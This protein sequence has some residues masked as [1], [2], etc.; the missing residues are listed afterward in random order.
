MIEEKLVGH[1]GV[2]YILQYEDCDDF[3]ILPYEEC[4]QIWGVC[5]TPEDKIVVAYNGKKDAWS[6]VG[7]TIE[8]GETLDQTFRREIQE[9][10]N[11]EV[12]SWKP[13]GYQKM[14]DTRDGSYVYQ[15]RVVA[16]VRPYGPFE[17]DPAGS[18]DKI[19][20]IDP[21]DYKKYFDYKRIGDR[22]MEGANKLKATMI[23]E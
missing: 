14:I 9:E 23:R 11:M 18:V 5:F 8:N 22:I 4:R 3:S 21:K 15:L 2:E 1:S 7:G 17:N 6:L 10:S 20:I 19:A 13:I 16:N 12:L